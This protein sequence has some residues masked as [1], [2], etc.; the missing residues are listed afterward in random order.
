M[1]LDPG[2]QYLAHDGKCHQHGYE[3][4]LATFFNHLNSVDPQIKFTMKSPDTDGGIPFLD[5]KCLLNKDQPTQTSVYR[6]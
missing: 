5:T 4:Q 6:K 1:A 3:N 2:C